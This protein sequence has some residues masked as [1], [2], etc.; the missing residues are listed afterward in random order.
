MGELELVETT[1][2]W[3]MNISSCMIFLHIL[4]L[5]RIGLGLTGL[6]GMD[7]QGWWWGESCSQSSGILIHDQDEKGD[8]LNYFYRH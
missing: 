4:G 2:L 5:R 6:A 3:I 8:P 1:N 7:K